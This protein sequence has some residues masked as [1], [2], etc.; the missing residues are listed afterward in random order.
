[1]TSLLSEKIILL[2]VNLITVLV[3]LASSFLQNSVKTQIEKLLGRCLSLCFIGI[4]LASFKITSQLVV[5]PF[6]NKRNSHFEV[7]LKIFS[8]ESW[9]NA[10]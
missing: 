1:M 5:V 4:P 6:N 7:C 8:L 10:S 2:D 9:Q 3:K